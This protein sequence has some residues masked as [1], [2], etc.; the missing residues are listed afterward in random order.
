MARAAREDRI[1]AR[2]A[3]AFRRRAL[4]I[5]V[6]VVVVVALVLLYVYGRQPP[7]ASNLT[8]VVIRTS[9]GDITIELFD[10][11]PITTSNFR[12]LVSQGAYD[13]TSSVN[14]TF[15]RVVKGFVVQGGDVSVKGINVATIQDELPNKHSNIRGSVAMAKTSDPNSATSQFYINLVDNSESLDSNYTVFGRVVD[16]M[17]AADAIAEV[18]VD[19]SKR[20]LQDVVI[21]RAELVEP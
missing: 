14:V 7:A 13:S 3:K 16:G 18:Q 9:M 17:D 21:F 6:I 20:P 5:A 19:E 11:M 2:K 12:N 4:A 8:K 10:D 15:H 1:K